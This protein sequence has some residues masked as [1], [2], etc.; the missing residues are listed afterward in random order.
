MIRMLLN[1]FFFW[2]NW[3]KIRNREVSR[4][5]IRVFSSAPM[6]LFDHIFH[7]S[8]R[9]PI[10]SNT[11][12]WLAIDQH[13]SDIPIYTKS[14][15]KVPPRKKKNCIR[16]KS[17]FGNVTWSFWWMYQKCPKCES[18]VFSVKNQQFQIENDP[19]LVRNDFFSSENNA[20]LIFLILYKIWQFLKLR[21]LIYDWCSTSDSSI[22]GSKFSRIFIVSESL[23]SK[24]SP[25]WLILRKN[26]FKLIE[27]WWCIRS[28][29]N[30]YTTS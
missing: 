10:S 3:D 13:P 6:V 26:W 16:T 14:E 23:Y 29:R 5:L 15:L 19:S 8:K 12:C 4:K 22:T 21:M 9:L 20:S 24:I 7:F 27:L 17:P 11:Q 28:G 30:I 2:L 1:W 18:R 25:K